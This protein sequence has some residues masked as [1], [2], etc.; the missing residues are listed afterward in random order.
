MKMG[1]VSALFVCVCLRALFREYC[2]AVVFSAQ[3]R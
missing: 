3:P 2:T 1:F